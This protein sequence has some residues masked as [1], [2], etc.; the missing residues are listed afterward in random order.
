[1]VPVVRE[2]RAGMLGNA[3][4]ASVASGSGILLVVLLVF[5]GRLLGDEDYGK[6]SYALILAMMIRQPP[7]A[8]RVH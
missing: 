8:R 6:F 3:V 4:R 2:S 5:A 7:A 1:M